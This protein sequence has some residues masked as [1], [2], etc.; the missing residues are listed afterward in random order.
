MQSAGARCITVRLYKGEF[1]VCSPAL[2]VTFP[3]TI[4]AETTTSFAKQICQLI[5]IPKPSH[6]QFILQSSHLQPK[7]PSKPSLP[8]K[9]FNHAPQTRCLTRLANPHPPPHRPQHRLHRPL[10]RPAAM[11]QGPAVDDRSP[12]AFRH[13]LQGGEMFGS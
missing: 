6:L 2:F 9:S 11:V 10:R 1:A 7:T 8:T 5:S 4:A 3:P 13:G 12:G